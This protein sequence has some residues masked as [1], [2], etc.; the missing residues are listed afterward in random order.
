MASPERQIKNLTKQVETL[1]QI[2][3]ANS[4]NYICPQCFCGFSEQRLLYH[5]FDKEKQNYPVHAALGERRS[6][7]LAFI[8]NY[9]IALRTLIDTKDIPPNPRCFALD[10]VVEHFGEHP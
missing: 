10:F 9:K 4:L 5:H 7:H 8:M 2:I 3:T 6:D 1:A